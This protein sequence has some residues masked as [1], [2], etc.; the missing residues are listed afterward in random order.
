M[1][2]CKSLNID[3]KNDIIYSTKFEM[4]TLHFTLVSIWNT[5]DG[6]HLWNHLQMKRREINI[7]KM[8]LEAAVNLFLKIYV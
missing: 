2:T 1:N 5:F 8:K 7:G 3:L 4:K 6:A